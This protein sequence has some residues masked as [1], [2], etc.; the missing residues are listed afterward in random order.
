M[1]DFSTYVLSQPLH[2]L[3]LEIELANEL[4]STSYETDVN[5]GCLN[6]SNHSKAR[7]VLRAEEDCFPFFSCRPESTETDS[8]TSPPTAATLGP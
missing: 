6:T 1:N 3:V 7:P 4:I 2:R 5:A 8:W